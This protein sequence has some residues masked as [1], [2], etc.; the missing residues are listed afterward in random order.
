[1]F[2]YIQKSAETEITMD[3]VLQHYSVHEFEFKYTVSV[4]FPY[5]GSDYDI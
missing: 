4:F 5:E 2:N 3:A 1:M